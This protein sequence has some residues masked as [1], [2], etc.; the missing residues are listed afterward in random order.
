ME[1]RHIR[2]LGIDERTPLR[3]AGAEWNTAFASYLQELSCPLLD[4]DNSFK[5]SEI[6][7]YLSWL[8]GKAISLD[9]EERAKD[10]NHGASAMLIA[11]SRSSATSAIASGAASSSAM[12]EDEATTAGT[13]GAK[14]IP[15]EA[16]ALITQL[17][18][19]CHVDATGRTPLQTLQR[20]HRVVR[21]RLLPAADALEATT[22]GAT[23][24]A[25][26]SGTGAR[27]SK[28][29]SLPSREPTREEI[30]T[31]SGFPLGLST[32][33][34]TLDAAARIL[35]MLYVADLRELQDAVT[36]LLVAVQEYTAD[37]KTDASLGAV[38]R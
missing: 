29:G 8:V 23:A 10:Y 35:R 22:Q 14:P 2:F 24:T 37:P 32:G 27:R 13:G 26:S 1:D 12:D 19:V 7:S 25:A 9:Y 33:Q 5:A 3:K 20:V 11:A 17:A 38:G 18:T 4:S 21:Q 16:L 36:D 31:G 30:L 34:A 6:P 28:P 15:A